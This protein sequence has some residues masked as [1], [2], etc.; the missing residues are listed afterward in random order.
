MKYKNVMDRRTFLRGAG[1]VAI[2][3]PFLDTMFTRSA[4]A[5]EM[6]PPDRLVTFFFGLG[7][8][9][10]Y[11]ENGWTG[12][13]EPLARF[14]N[15]LALLRGVDL[16]EADGSENNHF[17]G[18]GGVFVGEVPAGEGQAG[19]PSIDQVALQ[20]LHPSGSPT[21]IQTLM[22]GTWFRRSRPT[23]YVHSWRNDGTPVDV[24]TETPGQLFTRIFGE[25]PELEATDNKARRY[26]LSVLDS[27]TR[28][29][30]YIK[31]ER[32]GVGGATRAKVSDHLD[33]I[34][35]LERRVLEDQ[36]MA[37]EACR[38]PEAGPVSPA[39]LRDQNPDSGDNI[40]PRLDPD[41]FIAYWQLMTDLYVMALRCDLTRFG[42]AML[43]SAGERFRFRGEYRYN[44]N[45][46]AD[47]DDSQATHEYWHS[48]RA[49]RDNTQMDQHILF[50]ADQMAYFLDQLDDPNYTEENGKTL[51]DNMT[52]LFGT[53]LGD[54]NRHDLKSV[55]H[56]VSGGNGRFNV[57]QTLQIDSSGVDLYNTILRGHGITRRMGDLNHFNGEISELL[58]NPS[59]PIR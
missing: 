42:S 51:L 53:E 21:L 1:S 17:D 16:N 15:K 46:V 47:F 29:Y 7:I 6:A 52:L 24:P 43:M 8:P 38:A 12:P 11:T 33:R 9:K 54:G 37:T 58:L 44:G 18:G 57:G 26:R 35:E 40:G 55:F 22:T 2:G 32:S 48:Y 28:Q 34:R 5:N 45:L 20:E 4:F 50:M 14:S 3:L 31:S 39:L 36:M 41:E 59:D 30:Q 56:A 49:G 19:G 27:V 25:D 10:E 13:L 23:R